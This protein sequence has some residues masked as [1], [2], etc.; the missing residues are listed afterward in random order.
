VSGPGD[1]FF[2]QWSP[3]GSEVAYYGGPGPEALWLIPAGGGKATRLSDSGEVA[4]NARWSRDGLHLAY[5]NEGSSPPD[6]WLR[7]RETLQSPWGAPRQLTR[8]GCY[9]STWMPSGEGVVCRTGDGN[10]LVL[11]SLDGR[12]LWRRDFRRFGFARNP[13]VLARDSAYYFLATRGH[14]TGIWTMPTGGG[15]PRLLL[16]A[17]APET[18]LMGF[19]GSLSVTGDRL[20]VTV[21][22]IESD[23]WVTELH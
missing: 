1:Q 23:I 21:G 7:S 5:T 11:I 16:R 2:P 18:D 12:E 17:D 4:T 10:A 9:L 3:D 22:R 6:V 14:D 15:A 20:L 19:P 13:M 8:S